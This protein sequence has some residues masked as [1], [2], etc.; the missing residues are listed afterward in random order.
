MTFDVLAPLAGLVTP[1][2]EVS[3]PVFAQEIVGPGL[4]VTPRGGGP[5]DV[6]APIEGE[7]VKIHPHAFVL[8]HA[9]GVGVLVH[10]G[11]DTVTLKGAGFTLHRG[12]HDHVRAGDVLITWDPAAVAAR[13]LDPVVPVVVM[14]VGERTLERVAPDHAPIAAG[15]PLMRIG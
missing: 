7:I 10:L 1:M 6:V 15:A 4:A 14:E 12:D 9:S 11:I 2:R 8:R 3:D 13:D 5:V